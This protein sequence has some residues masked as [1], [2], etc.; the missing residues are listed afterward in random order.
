K[1][2]KDAVAAEQNGY[3]DTELSDHQYARDDLVRKFLLMDGKMTNAV[4]VKVN[5]A[6]EKIAGILASGDAKAVMES[7]IQR[8]CN[9]ISDDL[10]AEF[11]EELQL[12]MDNLSISVDGIPVAGE[13]GDSAMGKA[14]EGLVLDGL[15]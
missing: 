12:T 5:L 8:M 14:V 15:K 9:S 3:P 10:V 4:N 13:E 2:L 1:P 7:E 6:K 11:K